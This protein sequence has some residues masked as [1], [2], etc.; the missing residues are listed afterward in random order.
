MPSPIGKKDKPIEKR[1]LYQIAG[2]T[3]FY[4]SSEILIIFVL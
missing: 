2:K 1:L 3:A 4:H